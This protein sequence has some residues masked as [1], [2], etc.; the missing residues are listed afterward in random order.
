MANKTK[1]ALR[2]DNNQSFPDNNT[3][4]ITP[5]KLRTFQEDIID[6]F[7]NNADSGSLSFNSGSL[8]TTASA[9]GA[10]IEFT[11]GDGSTFDLTVTAEATNTGSLLQTSSF[12]EYTQ[13]TDNR[14]TNIEL[15]TASLD[16]RVSSIETFT[17]SVDTKFDTLASTTSSLN[18]LANR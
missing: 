11:K 10:T 15:E 5:E 7:V 13:S 16:G 3:G 14:L 12:N 6:S 8:L 4:F 18:T 2:V 17:S 9:T 1:Q